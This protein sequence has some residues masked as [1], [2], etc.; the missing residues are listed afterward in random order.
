ML[1]PAGA[2]AGLVAQTVSIFISIPIVAIATKESGIPFIEI[3]WLHGIEQLIMAM[4]VAVMAMSFRQAVLSQQPKRPLPR[5]A[6]SYVPMVKVI[7]ISYAVF[8]LLGYLHKKLG[9]HAWAKTPFL[10]GFLNPLAPELDT[11]LQTGALSFAVWVPHWIMFIDVATQ[12]RSMWHWAD[13]AKTKQWKDLALLHVPN[14][15]VMAVVIANHLHRDHV[16]LLRLLHPLFVFFGSVTCLIGSVRVARANGWAGR[17]CSTKN[18][19]QAI[20]IVPAAE[21]QSYSDWDLAYSVRSLAWRRFCPM[22]Q[23]I[24]RDSFTS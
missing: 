23:C 15:A 22:L 21:E 16:P 17:Q 9:G 18:S 14:G 13:C 24:L 2:A 11:S 3:D 20:G 4:P 1:C 6:T 7:S 8:G 12:I 19:L 10:G 5:S